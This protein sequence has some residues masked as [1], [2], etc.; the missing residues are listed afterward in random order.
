[1]A[2][3]ITVNAFLCDHIRTLSIDYDVFLAGNI[4]DEDVKSLALTG[5]HRIEI[6]RGISVW[7]DLKS[8][9]HLMRYIRKMRFDAVHSVTPKAG[10]TTALAGMLAGTKHRTHI[11]TGQVW[12]THRGKMRWM[13][14]F[15]DKVIVSLDNHIMADGKSQRAFLESEGVLH[16]GQALVFANGSISG[17]NSVRF[18]PNPDVRSRIRQ[19]I[20]IKKDTL[21]YIFLG[22]LN[23]DKGIEELYEAF[24]RLAGEVQDVFLLLV[25]YD[26]GG[27]INWLPT[28]KNIMNG[29][30]FHYYGITSEPEK[31]LNAGDVFVLPTYREGFG[32][33]VLEA[34]CVGLPCICSDAY[35]VLDSYVE[36]ET[37]LRCK[38]GDSESLYQCMRQMYEAPDMVKIMGKNSRER[39][40]RDFNGAD[41]TACWVDF[42]HQILK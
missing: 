30:N 34:A 18:V 37:G 42:Y 28:Y 25:G 1:M 2:V 22:R 23:H 40:L 9:W 39:A 29:R 32:T 5:W 19:E 20:G 38:V 6:E 26:E 4:K 16:E 12:A 8:V 31:V 36:G 7:S 11:F 3:P 41:L 27:Y 17:V 10:L 15:L 35:G 33:S 14:K 21:C 13:L 24:N